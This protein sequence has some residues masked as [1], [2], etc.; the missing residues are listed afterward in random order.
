MMSL[1]LG[2]QAG[3]YDLDDGGYDAFHDGLLSVALPVTV[4][5]YVTISPELYY[6]FPLS[7]EA[8]DELEATSVDGD[9]DSFLY[10]G[11]AVSFAF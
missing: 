2:A 5:D 4:N 1:D 3:Y 10:G 8:S 6:S 7:D 9:D 11:V